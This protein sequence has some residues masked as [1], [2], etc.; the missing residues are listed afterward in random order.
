MI[1]EVKTKAPSSPLP[2]YAYAE[3]EVS[4]N[5]TQTQ[6]VWTGTFSSDI[7]WSKIFIKAI[8]QNYVLSAPCEAN[9]RPL[10]NTSFY[11][12][13]RNQKKVGTGGILRVMVLLDRPVTLTIS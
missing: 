5:T 1:N 10:N 2:Y 7:D 9:V 12:H 11:V 13:V 3:K 8:F 4:W 6:M